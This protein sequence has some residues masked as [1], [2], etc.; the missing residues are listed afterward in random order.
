MQQDRQRGALVLG[1]HT[2]LVALFLGRARAPFD[3]RVDEL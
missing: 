3:H 2:W 1:R